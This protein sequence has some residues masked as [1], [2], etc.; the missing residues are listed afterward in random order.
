MLE[1]RNV[2]SD[3]LTVDSGPTDKPAKGLLP[4]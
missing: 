2:P 4:F 1:D 3:P